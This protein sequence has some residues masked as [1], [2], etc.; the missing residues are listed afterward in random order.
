MRYTT[1]YTSVEKIEYE[2]DKHDLLDILVKHLTGKNPYATEDKW[3]IDYVDTYENKHDDSP[4]GW[5]LKL[6]RKTEKPIKKEK[7]E[8]VKEK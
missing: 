6:I 4:S 8:E 2:F 1:Y 5:Y 7:N 3:D